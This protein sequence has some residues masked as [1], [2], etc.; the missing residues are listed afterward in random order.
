M[1]ALGPVGTDVTF[2]PLRGQSGTPSPPVASLLLT[3]RWAGQL[4]GRQ[5]VISRR[6]PEREE[7]PP[8]SISAGWTVLL[9]RAPCRHGALLSLNHLADLRSYEPLNDGGPVL[10]T[11]GANF[12]DVAAD[13]RRP[14]RAED[15]IGLRLLLVDQPGQPEPQELSE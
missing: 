3:R 11:A 9:G 7:G 14:S 13:R 5:A 10:S 4:I 6:E 2:P 1:A 12:L 8:A 15:P